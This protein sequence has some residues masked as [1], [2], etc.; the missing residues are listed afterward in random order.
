MRYGLKL[1]KKKEIQVQVE[2]QTSCPW[3]SSST[4]VDMPA[5]PPPI[6]ATFSLGPLYFS[7]SGGKRP[8]GAETIRK[9]K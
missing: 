6:I 4:A 8:F 2:V 9:M 3:S 7:G 1:E 5:R